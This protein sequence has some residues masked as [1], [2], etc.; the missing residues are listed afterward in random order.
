MA[1]VDTATRGAT[2]QSWARDSI[3]TIFREIQ[4][5]HPKAGHKQLVKLLAERMEEDPGALRAAADYI[6]QICLEAL[7]GYE[8]RQRQ[9]SPVDPAQRAKREAEI[10]QAAEVAVQQIM[11][12]NQEMPNGKRMR[13]CTGVEMG[14]FGKGYQL[15]AKRC[16]T[17]MVGSAMNE[18]EV[19]QLMGRAK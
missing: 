14:K 9:H 11:L 10:A 1:Y 19:R 16:G 6:V 17:K 13:F 5:E 8:R 7:E 2:R 15:I 4:V 3:R 18:D 12:L